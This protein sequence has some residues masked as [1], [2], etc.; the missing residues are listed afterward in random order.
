MTTVYNHTDMKHPAPEDVPDERPADPAPD[1]INELVALFSQGRYRET[2]SAARGMTEHFPQHGFGWKVLG[3]ALMGQGRVAEALEPTQR[4]AELLPLDAEAR[5]NLAN[6]IKEL[7]RLPEAEAYYRLA[8]EIRPDYAG[9]CYNLGITLAEM[10]RLPE[11]E[12]C[13]RRTLELAPDHAEAHNNLGNLLRET[14][15]LSEAEASYR[16]ALEVVPD[17]IAAHYNLGRSLKTMGRFAEA[18]ACY[19]HV[20][21]IVPNYAEAHYNLGNI[22]QEQGRFREAEASYRRALEIRADF[23]EAYNNLGNSLTAQGRPGEAEASFRRAF[24]ICP[25]FVEAYSNLGNLLGDQN[26]HREA[27]GLFRLALA[28]CPDFVE[29]HSNLGNV[30]AGQGRLTEAEACYR[31]ALELR[32]EYVEAHNNLGSALSLMG[33]FIDAEACFRRALEI[34][35]EYAEAYNNLGNNLKGQG[36]LREAEACFR[37]AIAIRPDYVEA[38]SNLL[39]ALNFNS[40]HSASYCLEEACRYGRMIKN[41]VAAPFDAW[42]CRVSP[43][44]LKVG[45][46]SGDLRNH[47]VGY[48]LESL[49]TR[50]D[51]SSLDLVAYPTILGEDGL[52]A[53]IKPHFSAWTPLAGLNDEAAARHI[54]ED[55][56]HILID[57]A[58]HTADNRLPVFAWKPAPVQAAWLGYLATTG[59]SEIDYVLGDPHATPSEDVG[60][61]SE[62]IWQLPDVWCCFTPPQVPVEVNPLPAL[63]AGRITFGSFNNLSKMNDAVVALWARVLKAVP[64]SRLFLKTRQLDDPI[65]CDAALRR[66]AVHG[67]APERLLL[68][69][70][71]PRAELLAAYQRVD[72]ALD[73]FPYGG[74]TTTFEVL[75]MAVP[76]LTLKG[77]RFLSRC[78][79]S[80]AFNAGLADW[81]AE[82][83]DDYVAKAV[84]HTKDLETLACL[85]SG[86]R[87]Q[88]LASPLFDAERFARNFE[89]ALWGMWREYSL[90]AHL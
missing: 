58:G 69:G 38:Y 47:P 70:A 37:R 51:Q 1:E 45:V 7:G 30:L 29:A 83:E 31:Q 6:T 79:H 54:H 52:T 32:P 24:E 75:W 22:C 26:R 41:K 57:L 42:P 78:G 34:F 60:Q 88:V 16:L 27:E 25:D 65:V 56:V 50:L 90:E 40:A 66:F 63:T 81:I 76:V 10:G 36:L 3:A 87:R 33:R 13:Y 68:E 21:E 85:R 18:E 82:D 55:G 17:F 72:I 49:L 28:R 80:L 74:G 5:C 8:L 2:E 67:I 62:K 23:F 44:R 64:G 77:D 86:L 73:P 43:K 71:S 9:A 15:R 14:G 46:V 61:F 4:A 35:P 84:T 89:E 11:A 39:L 48:F 12:A 20:I 59:V 19:R 53:R